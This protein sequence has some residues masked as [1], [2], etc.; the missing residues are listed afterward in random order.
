[1]HAGLDDVNLGVFADKGD[2]LPYHDTIET[3]PRELYREPRARRTHHV[4]L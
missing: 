2:P 3:T 1:M 4:V